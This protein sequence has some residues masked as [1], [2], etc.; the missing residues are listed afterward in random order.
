MM[1]E[2]F[3]QEYQIKMYNRARERELREEIEKEVKQQVKQ[4]VEQQIAE[5]KRETAENTALKC[6]KTGNISKN[7]I[8]EITGLSPERIEELAEQMN[9]QSA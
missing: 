4:Q 9:Q 8:A 5:T 6:L 1:A 2:L 7:D 3:D